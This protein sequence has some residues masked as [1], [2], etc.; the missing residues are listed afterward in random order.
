MLTTC[1]SGVNIP[2]QISEPCLGDYKS[3]KCVLHPDALP[4]LDLP[5]SSPIYNIIIAQNLAILSNRILINAVNNIAEVNTTVTPLS[6]AQLTIAYPT[7]I[8]GAKV[9]AENINLMYEKTLTGW[10]SY[11][12]NTVV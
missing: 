11:S 5:A 10:I 9:K 1:Q 4:I 8:V 2:P 12:I 7:A 3:S 6:L